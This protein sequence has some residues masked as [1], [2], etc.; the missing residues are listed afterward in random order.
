MDKNIQLVADTISKLAALGITAVDNPS[1]F[2]AYE[3]AWG[4]ISNYK[5]VV[6]GRIREMQDAC[7]RT[8]LGV[9]VSYE[10]LSES[11]NDFEDYTEKITRNVPLSILMDYL[12]SRGIKKC[13][14]VTVLVK[15]V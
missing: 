5:K 4:S 13:K 6:I 11:G 10:A 15:E 3:G 14:K 9:F 12:E 7:G 1:D 8:H 2:K